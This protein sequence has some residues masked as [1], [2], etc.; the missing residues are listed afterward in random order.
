MLP[1]GLGLLLF[2]VPCLLAQRIQPSDLWKRA[3]A[4]ADHRLA[5][6]QDALQFGELRLPKEK[7]LFPVVVLVHGGC[8]MDRLP[9]RDPRDT[10]FEALRPL[11]AALAEAGVAT[12]NVE[13]RRV[14]NAG[15][16]WPGSFLDLA[17][18]VDFLRSVASAYHLDLNR[19][20]IVGHSAGGQ[21]AQWIAARGKLPR[22]SGLYVKDPL[23]V[24]AVVN[25]DGPPDLAAAQPL[26][27]NFCPVPGITDFMGGSPAEHP[28]RYREGSAGALLPTGVPQ[29]IV[30]GGLLLRAYELV[31]AY[32]AAAKDKG[33]SVT[34]LKLEGSGHFDMLAPEGQYGKKVVEAIWAL[35][36]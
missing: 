9:N 35:V 24:K 8:W 11:A 2:L 5:Y 34:V 12:W 31:S 3:V 29:T 21:L 17:A 7:R 36:R 32:E 10:S 13:Y 19:V 30:A 14:G 1:T 26:E 28:E 18:A 23:P 33:E 22:A 25:V 6:G 16:G 27:R 4:A 15:G 20:V